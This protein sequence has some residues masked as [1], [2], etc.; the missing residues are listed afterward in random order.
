MSV[1]NDDLAHRADLLFVVHQAIRFAVGG[2]P[3]GG[4]IGEQV[5]AVRAGECGHFLGLFERDGHRLLDHDVHAAWG[6]GLHDL[7]MRQRRAERRAGVGLDFVEQRAQVMADERRVEADAARLFGGEFG[8]GFVDADEFEVVALRAVK[9]PA[10][11]SVIEAG[12][13]EACGCHGE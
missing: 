4:E 8:V 3:A 10:D 12:D 6:A 7:Q 2:E 11:M 13:D 1:V 5:N 9:P